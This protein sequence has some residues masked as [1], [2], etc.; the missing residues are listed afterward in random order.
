MRVF[1]AA[2]KAVIALLDHERVRLETFPAHAEFQE[3]LG[4]QRIVAQDVD[5]T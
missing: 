5:E 3:A 4:L 1:L 2:A